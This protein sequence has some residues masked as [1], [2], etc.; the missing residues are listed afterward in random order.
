MIH[1]TKILIKKCSQKEER[2]LI[3]FSLY[4]QL[5]FVIRMW[6]KIKELI[7]KFIKYCSIK[8]KILILCWISYRE[9]NKVK[10]KQR[11][12]T[13]G[14]SWTTSENC[15]RCNCCGRYI[16][17][18]RGT[19]RTNEYWISINFTLNLFSLATSFLQFIAIHVLIFFITSC[20]RILLLWN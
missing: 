9:W 18:R 3:I 16:S 11:G 13:Q 20:D 2:H 10:C 6:K 17:G 19:S 15:C 5:R 12:T 8:V 7:I 4:F 14:C 1:D